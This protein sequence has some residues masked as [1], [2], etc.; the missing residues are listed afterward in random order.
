LPAGTE[1]RRQRTEAERGSGLTE[2]ERAR[3]RRGDARGW[4][5]GEADDGAGERRRRV[6][7]GQPA[8]VNFV[9]SH[10]P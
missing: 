5:D 7:I 4:R 9:S 6:K 8:G 1:K 2:G 3:R 10:G